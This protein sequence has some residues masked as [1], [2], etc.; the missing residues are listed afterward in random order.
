MKYNNHLRRGMAY[1][2]SSSGVLQKSGPANGFTPP[3]QQNLT[4]KS[5]EEIKSSCEYFCFCWSKVSKIQKVVEVSWSSSQQEVTP[6]SSY[7]C[8]CAKQKATKP[9]TAY[10]RASQGPACTTV[11][12]VKMPICRNTSEYNINSPVNKE[13]IRVVYLTAITQESTPNENE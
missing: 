8:Q 4:N 9:G 5:S 6:T 2:P 11:A 3:I 13:S 12:V 7:S 10:H 1:G